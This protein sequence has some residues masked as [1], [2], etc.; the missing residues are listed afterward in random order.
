MGKTKGK[1]NIDNSSKDTPKKKL[2]AHVDFD[3]YD[4]L[5]TPEEDE[6]WAKQWE[7]LGIKVPPK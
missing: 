4:D 7:K 2:K 1:E 3:V 6:I 5:S